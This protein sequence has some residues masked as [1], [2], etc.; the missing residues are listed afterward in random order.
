MIMIKNTPS[1]DQNY[2]SPSCRVHPLAVRYGLCVS[3]N[4]LPPVEEEDA[5]IDGWGN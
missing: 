4:A 3:P 2:M 5:G 1:T